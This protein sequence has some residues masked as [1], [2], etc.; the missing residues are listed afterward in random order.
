MPQNPPD[1]PSSSRSGLAPVVENAIKQSDTFEAGAKS[2]ARWLITSVAIGLLFGM[3]GC[4]LGVPIGYK[5][6][7]HFALFGGFNLL[8]EPNS[9]ARD[10]L[11][12]G[13]I[14]IF[15]GF[16]A[17]FGFLVGFLSILSYWAFSQA[18][19]SSHQLFVKLP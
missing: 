10:S 1:P 11:V 6:A 18:S 5:S 17:I 14:A 7:H 13:H 8:G 16:F 9:P 4:C 2:V 3:P 15:A 12:P 19:R